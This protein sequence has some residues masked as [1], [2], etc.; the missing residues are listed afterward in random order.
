MSLD[1]IDTRI[2]TA[3]IRDARASYAVIGSEVGLSVPAVYR[4]W[5]NEPTRSPCLS[6]R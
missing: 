1:D 5:S 2:I 3:L 4:D 6:A